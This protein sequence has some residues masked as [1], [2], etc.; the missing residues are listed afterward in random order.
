[1]VFGD[2]GGG[3]TGDGM[4][5]ELT[6][7]RA[8]HPTVRYRAH[9]TELPGQEPLD[10]VWTWASDA[11]GRTTT[12]LVDAEIQGLTVHS[13]DPR[14]VVHHAGDRRRWLIDLSWAQWS[15]AELRRGSFWDHLGRTDATELGQHA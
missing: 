4:T 7:A 6:Y 5:P 10:S 13:T 14:H 2:Y 8:R 3:A 1:M 12:A 11:V 15:Y 9:P